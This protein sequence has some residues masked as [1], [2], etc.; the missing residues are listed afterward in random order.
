MV[1][2]LG[3]EKQTAHAND[4]GEWKVTLP[5]MDA[6]GPYILTVSGSNT[7]QYDDVMIGEVWLCSGQSNMEFGLGHSSKEEIAAANYP[8]IRLLMVKNQWTP[9]PQNDMEG[10]WKICTPETVAADGWQGFSAV[11][12]YFGRELH[13]KLGVPI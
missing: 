5:Q 4:R 11:G 12:F 2:Q 3:A 6:G 10:A 9:Q 13:E 8:G 7:V 1:V